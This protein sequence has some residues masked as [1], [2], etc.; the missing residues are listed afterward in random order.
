MLQVDS[1]PWRHAAVIGLIAVLSVAGCAPASSSAS[2]GSASLV[3]APEGEPGEPL[4]VEG[5]VYGSGG[6]PLAGV[7]VE[8]VQTGADGYYRRGP[9]G[10]ELSSRFAR[11][12]GRL[13]TGEDGG[14]RI[15][16]I[17]P[18]SYPG[19]T[20]PAHV[21]FFVEAP[22]YEGQ[23]LT[24]YFAGDPLLPADSGDRFMDDPRTLIRPLE[25]AADGVW[26]CRVELR[27]PGERR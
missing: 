1:R 18:G 16:T 9:G 12:K 6:A 7:E 23:E 3:L 13:V 22:G 25:Q 27:P 5:T 4:V 11:L 17:R 20:V 21:H 26:H 15:R 10:M 2:D 8:T 19:D 24:L 14:F